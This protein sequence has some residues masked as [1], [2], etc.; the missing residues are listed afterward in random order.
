MQEL[1]YS[2]SS[3]FYLSLL[4]LPFLPVLIQPALLPLS[5]L[6][7]LFSIIMHGRILQ[8][9]YKLALPNISVEVDLWSRTSSLKNTK[10]LLAVT[11]HG[12]FNQITRLP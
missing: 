9:Q 4:P 2:P 1:F 5:L 8:I 11:L 10:L 12:I 3:F 7:F 6:S